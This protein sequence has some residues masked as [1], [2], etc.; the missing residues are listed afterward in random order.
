MI[1]K[2]IVVLFIVLLVLFLVEGIRM[3]SNPLINS[4]ANIRDLLLEKTPI[5]TKM[6]DVLEFIEVNEEWEVKSINYE[7]G[8]YHQRITPPRV[9]GEKSI[10]V[11]LG[12][13][14]VIRNMYFETNVTVFYGFD[15]NGELVEI[16]V[17]KTTDAL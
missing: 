12:N 3:L 5:G 1:K 9:I 2:I 6:E 11:S 15:E 14:R 13:Y 8:F 17:W 10:R 7:T 16:W 4:E